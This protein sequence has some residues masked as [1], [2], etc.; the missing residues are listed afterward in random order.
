MRGWI[1][2]NKEKY[3]NELTIILYPFILG[4][5]SLIFVFSILLYDISNSI[6]T[7]NWHSICVDILFMS[8]CYIVLI[9]LFNKRAKDYIKFIEKGIIIKTF[10]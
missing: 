6:K 7:T 10:K 3:R 9:Y 4:L 2:L 5:L 1:S 8:I